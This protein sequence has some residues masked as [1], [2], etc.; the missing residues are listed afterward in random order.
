MYNKVRVN[1]FEYYDVLGKGGYGV[2][3]ECR[4]KST[5]KRYAM[6]IQTKADML[7]SFKNDLS[8]IALEA[9]ALSNVRHPFIIGMDYSFQT[10]DYAILVMELAEGILQ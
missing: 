2:V 10:A 1:D 8:Q 9:R 3:V 4:K 5:G 6:K 7:V